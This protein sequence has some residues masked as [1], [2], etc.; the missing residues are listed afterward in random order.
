MKT[1]LYY[2]SLLLIANIQTLDAKV[3][4]E[5]KVLEPAII[6]VV[7]ERTQV[8]D[9]LNAANDYKQDLLTLKA[10]KKYSA[11]Y[12]ADRKTDD[13]I[14]NRN[15]DYVMAVM[16]DYQAFHR[17]AELE[18][19]VIF[20]NYP[21]G[22]NTVFLRFNLASW[23]YQEPIEKPSWQLVS[24]STKVICGYECLKAICNYRGR[25][26]TAWYS[27]EIPIHDGPWKLCGLPGLILEAHDDKMHYLYTALKIQSENA[28]NV[29]YFNYRDRFKTERIKALVQSRKALGKSIKNAILSSGAFGVKPQNIKADTGRPAHTNYDFEE[30][31][32]PHE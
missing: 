12:S 7:Y 26:W 21:E 28:G 15:F 27:P 23:Y 17:L 8:T 6:S 31:D 19:G 32:Y 2:I 4:I 11:F 18:K 25:Q 22:E 29:E 16:K 24:D 13:S 9:T 30:T 1:Y 20:K 10:G 5:E 3:V 14:S